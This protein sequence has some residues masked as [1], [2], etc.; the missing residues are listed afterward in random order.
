MKRTQSNIVNTAYVVNNGEA[1]DSKGRKIKTQ[2]IELT[3]ATV[4]GVSAGVGLRTI[5]GAQKSAQINL[6][7]NALRDLLSAVNEIIA[8]QGSN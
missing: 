3:H 6:D 8:D 2:G 7:T 1:E 5:N 4:N